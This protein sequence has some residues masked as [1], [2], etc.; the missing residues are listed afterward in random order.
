[1]KKNLFI[2]IL[3]LAVLPLSVWAGDVNPGQALEMAKNFMKGKTFGFDQKM[4]D[5]EA[6]DRGYYA[7]NAEEG[8]F[9]LVCADDRAYKPI[10]AYSESGSFNYNELPDYIKEFFDDL[11]GQIQALTDADK[12]MKVSDGRVYD[13]QVGPLIQ[14]KWNQGKPFNNLCPMKNGERCV[15]GCVA[16]ALAQIMY[17]WKFPARGNGTATY[18][19]R[20]DFSTLTQNL[21]HSTFDYPNM[22]PSYVDDDYSYIGT[23]AQQHAV[24]VLMRD[25][26]YALSM[27]YGVGG[28]VDS[29]SGANCTV[30]DLVYTFGFDP[31]AKKYWRADGTLSNKEWDAL[32]KSELDAGRPIMYSGRTTESGHMFI[33]DGYN[34]SGYFHFN[35]GWGGWK[36]S[37]YATTSISN[38]GGNGFNSNQA[39]I[40]GIKPGTG[41]PPA[42]IPAFNLGLLTD[43]EFT[44]AAGNTKQVKLVIYPS[45]ATNKTLLWKS[46]NESVATVSADGTVTGVSAGKTFILCC[47]DEIYRKAAEVTVTGSSVAVSTLS[48]NKTE[49][50]L[51]KGGSQ[52][53]TATVTPS[54]ADKSVTWNSD[55]PAVAT[56]ASDGTVKAV[57]IGNA[58]ITCVSVKDP[59]KKDQCNVTVVAAAVSK[60]TVTP[61]KL[62]MK[63]NDPRQQLTA[64]ITPDGAPKDVTWT[65]SNEA[66]ATVDKD[67]WVTPHAVG[68]ATITCASASAP[69]KKAT[70]KVTVTSST[71]AVTGVKLTKTTLAMMD[72]GADATVNLSS[73]VVVS[74]TGAPTDVTWSSNNEAVASVSSTGVV[75]AHAVGNA[76]ITCT[77]KS[78]PAKKATCKVTVKTNK[79]AVSGVKLAEKTVTVTNDEKDPVDLTPIITPDNAFDKSVTWSSSDPSIADVF[80]GRVYGKQIGTATITCTSVS[81]PTKKATCKVTVVDW[82]IPA[83]GI[84]LNFKELTHT[85]GYYGYY[86]P[87]TLA[88]TVEPFKAYDREVEWSCSNPEVAEMGAPYQ[89]TH[90]YAD[91]GVGI[92]FKGAGTATITCS[93]KS[94]PKIKATC[95][96]TVTK[97]TI[98]GVMFYNNK[99]ELIDTKTATLYA[100]IFPTEASETRVKFT[101]SNPSLVS[102]TEN[103]MNPWCTL[104]PGTGTGTATITCTSEVDPTKSATCEVTVRKSSLGVTSLTLD[105]PSI[106]VNPGEEFK[107]TPTLMPEYTYDEIEWNYDGAVFDKA[108]IAVL[109]GDPIPLH[110]YFTAKTTGVYSITCYAKNHPSKTATCT[111]TVVEGD[112]VKTVKLDK[113]S[114]TVNS[115]ESFKL[116]PILTPTTANKV[117]NWEIVRN[118]VPTDLYRETS[119]GVSLTKSLYL[120]GTYTITCSSVKDPTKKATCK[121]TVKSSETAV[122]SVKLDKTSV[123]VKDEETF[124]INATVGPDNAYE[125]DLYFISSDPKVV[126]IH[127]GNYESMTWQALRPG[128]ATITYYSKWTPAKKATCKVTVTSDKPAVQSVTLDQTTK[129]IGVGERFTLTPTILPSGHHDP[130]VIWTSSNAAIASVEDG[131]VT[132]VKAGSATITCQSLWTSSKKATCKVTVKN[133][134][135]DA[136]SDE[137]T[138]GV[139]ENDDE[140]FAEGADEAVKTFDVFDLQGRKVASKV[141]SLD[142]LPKGIYIVDGKKLFKR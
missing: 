27:D 95:K 41:T 124:V 39:M 103:T 113:T 115:S 11:T 107:L 44:L 101:S 98:T 140:T 64:D 111:V 94:N 29:G 141:T 23:D 28:K 127:S 100:R 18:T 77:S 134:I 24:A 69:A 89:W 142:G 35:L 120:P 52:K 80:N 91:A 51:T 118:G 31:G 47:Y 21:S 137:V 73:Y 55:N 40:V 37:F 72:E 121:V 42:T 14:T 132:G 96:V 135:A 9:V 136:G 61:T 19:W 117:M 32:I 38:S 129:Q 128:T 79:V 138:R 92:T 30:E 10:I 114:L 109:Q 93:L 131:V 97:P 90:D 4:M 34:S 26:G 20:Y 54:N 12:P 76:T 86:I 139:I 62:S 22:L 85:L 5:N 48:L 88:A 75:T 81:N 33:C 58:T 6:S 65:S 2:L 66:I 116:V 7:F 84:N 56:V 43:Y 67:G 104:T 16:T 53:L 63:D 50:Q 82:K 49:L 59:S 108:L 71:I 46:D 106:T 105:Q 126:T 119:E 110:A 130:S 60:V 36:D 83:T 87:P 57:G 74:P 123:K 70:C 13:G 125:K 122:S 102:V 68:T 133:M 8:G 45:T 112:P 17:Y 1:M 25:C 15:T 99:V 3:L 78:N